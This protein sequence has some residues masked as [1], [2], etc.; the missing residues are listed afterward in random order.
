MNERALQQQEAIRAALAER[1]A[2][3]DTEIYL[4][5][6]EAEALDLA[7]GCVPRTVQALART[8]LEWR[9]QDER[10]AARPVKSQKRKSA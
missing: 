2:E 8:A 5:V 6:N 3:H 4:L 10:N 9:D 1:N 7:A